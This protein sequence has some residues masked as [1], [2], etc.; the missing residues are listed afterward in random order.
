METVP[1][2]RRF[3]KENGSKEKAFS[4]VLSRVQTI[5]KEK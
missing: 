4:G 3:E 2:G 5:S 1:S